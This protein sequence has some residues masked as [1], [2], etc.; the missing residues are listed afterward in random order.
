L[1][2]DECAPPGSIRQDVQV[3]INDPITVKATVLGFVA[4]PIDEAQETEPARPRLTARIRGRVRK[5]GTRPHIEVIRDQNMWNHDRQRAE[6]CTRYINRDTNVY[7]EV[8]TMPGTNDVVWISEPQALT[9][10]TH[11]AKRGGG[12]P[13]ATP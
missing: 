2:C 8:W 6:D 11:D 13:S 10:H 3:I 9:D 5:P 7:R 1:F 4:Q 12:P